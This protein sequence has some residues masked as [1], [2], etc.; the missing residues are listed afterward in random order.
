[1]SFPVIH[2]DYGKSVIEQQRQTAL[3]G[4]LHKFE[5]VLRGARRKPEFK[6]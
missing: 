5:A 2:T 6:F 1:M 4:C 3:K